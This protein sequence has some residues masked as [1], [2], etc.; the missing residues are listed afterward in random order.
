M[1][2]AQAAAAGVIRPP[3]ALQHC[4]RKHCSGALDVTRCHEMSLVTGGHCRVLSEPLVSTSLSVSIAIVA[5][6]TAASTVST[7]QTHCLPY[8]HCSTAALLRHSGRVHWLGFIIIVHDF[9][10]CSPQWWP[11]IRPSTATQNHRATNRHP[12][13]M[14]KSKIALYVSG[15]GGNTEQE[16]GS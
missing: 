16:R 14:G 11:V 9:K 1:T 12:Q 4:S 2:R 6:S 5:C 3:S 13:E 8:L 10:L 7:L 15:A